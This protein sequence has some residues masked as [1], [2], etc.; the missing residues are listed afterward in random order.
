MRS[1]FTFTSSSRVLTLL[2]VA[3]LT[4]L[5]MERCRAFTASAPLRQSLG[6]SF[7][8]R[9]H[10]S[11]ALRMMLEPLN[12]A[13]AA[14]SSTV[15]VLADP[16]TVAAAAVATPGTSS[17]LLLAATEPW[18]QPAI[19][20]LDPFL[21]LMSLAML[22]RVV[23]SWYPEVKITEMPWLILTVT[24]EPLLRAVKGF[25]PPAFGVDITPVFW[26]A[27]FTFVHEILLGQQGLLTMKVKYGI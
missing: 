12:S 13:A 20:V 15:G 7:G 9:A 17:A 24:T 23:L 11:S 18:V 25:V 2:F 4:P 19:F 27:V 21:N 5:L 14:A 26:V 16:T 10:Q 6:Q 1:F 8:M 22:A 3:T